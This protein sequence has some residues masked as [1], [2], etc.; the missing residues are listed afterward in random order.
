MIWNSVKCT[1]GINGRNPR[2]LGQRPETRL[3]NLKGPSLFG[4]CRKISKIREKNVW[5]IAMKGEKKPDEKT[6]SA[7]F[8][9]STASS[10]KNLGGLIAKV[11]L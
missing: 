3:E 10:P 1:V 7:I 2:N 6:Q 11:L 9:I 4:A 8:V 5:K